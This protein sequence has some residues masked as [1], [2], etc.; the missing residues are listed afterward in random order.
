MK[1]NCN[2]SGPM[3]PGKPTNACSEATALAV[4]PGGSTSTKP[5]APFKGLRPDEILER[6]GAALTAAREKAMEAA[7]L[8]CAFLD[9]WRDGSGFARL[10]TRFPDLNLQTLERLEGLGRGQIC[11]EL[12]FDAS[13]GAKCVQALPIEVQKQLVERKM[14]VRVMKRAAEGYRVEEKPYDRLSVA[15]CN[16]CFKARGEG[17]RSD[18]EMK[19]VL[20]RPIKVLRRYVIDMELNEV[21]FHEGCRMNAAQLEA[22]LDQL[23]A[24][25]MKRL[26]DKNKRERGGAK[27]AQAQALAT[28]KGP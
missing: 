24:E 6:L 23:K 27:S 22:L 12:V 18:G 4:S 13:Y 17:M 8:V 26:G 16:L 10:Q 1:K 19:D 5:G 2:D 9:S 7:L 28:T 14:P 25:E 20:S 3:K 15:E 21:L 11:E